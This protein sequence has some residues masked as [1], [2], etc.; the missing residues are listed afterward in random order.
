MMNKLYLLVVIPALFLFGCKVSGSDSV[1]A[2]PVKTGLSQKTVSF[3]KLPPSVEP[4]A[5]YKSRSFLVT[6]QSGGNIIY[7]DS[8]LSAYGTVTIYLYLYIPPYAVTQSVNV[9]VNLSQ[10]ALTGDFGM[11]F[12]PSPTTLLKSALLTFTVKGLDPLSLPSDPADIQFVYMDNAT[13][14]PMN[15]AYIFVDVKHGAL[16]IIGGEVPHFS[17]YGWSNLDDSSD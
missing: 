13:Y 1:I 12:G 2:P 5:I 3:I 6:P 16:S 7:S 17:R 15:A 11:D 8:Y 9:N 4:R 10:D 14:V